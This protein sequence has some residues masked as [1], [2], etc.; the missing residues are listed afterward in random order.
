MLE[1]GYVLVDFCE[2]AAFF[3]YNV[4]E[5]FLNGTISFYK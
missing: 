2:I 4:N 3:G 5:N 1:N